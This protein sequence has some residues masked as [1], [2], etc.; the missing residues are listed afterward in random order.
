MTENS[1]QGENKRGF[2]T[3]LNL[4]YPTNRHFLNPEK[5]CDTR[6]VSVKLGY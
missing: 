2:F 3:I 5:S 4:M 6:L 1:V